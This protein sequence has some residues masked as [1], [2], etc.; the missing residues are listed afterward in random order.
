MGAGKLILRITRLAF[1][2]SSLSICWAATPLFQLLNTYSSG[3]YSPVSLAVADLNGDGKMDV[4]V[5]NLC[6]TYENCPGDGSIGVLLGNGDGTL[7]PPTTYK[8]GGQHTSWVAVGDVNSDGKPDIIT[9]SEWLVYGG[10]GAVGI[11]LGNGDGTFK[12]PVTYLSGGYF[13]E[14]V[15]IADFNHD[16]IP[17]LA[18]ADS[19]SACIDGSC[20]GPGDVSILQGAGDG[21]FQEPKTYPSG[22]YIADSIAAADIN[23][24]GA[25]DLLVGHFG[26]IGVLLGKGDGTFQPARTYSS[27]GDYNSWLAISDVNRDGKL[28]LLVTNARSQGNSA[29]GRVGVLLGNGDGRFQPVTTYRSSGDHASSIAVTNVD[30]D[31]NLDILV[32][33]GHGLNVL[34]GHGDGT[35]VHGAAGPFIA[36]A[37]TVADLDRDG[38]IDVIEA[39]SDQV[40]VL[41]NIIP[42][43]TT[44]SLTSSLNPSIYGQSVTLTAEI[45]FE[46]P[47]TPTGKITF[48]SNGIGIGTAALT[49][50]VATLTK[51]NLPAG[52]LQITAQ[53]TGDINFAR[54]VS[55]PLAQEVQKASTTTTIASSLNPSLQG[56]PVTFVAKVTSVTTRVIGTVT[57]TAGNITL[58]SVA[59]KSGK[60][61]ITTSNLPPGSTEI[62]ATYAGTPN[63]SGS[64]AAVIQVVN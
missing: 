5:A 2:I 31:H 29:A 39:L 22:H 49:N 25:V 13:S 30:R 64:S 4:V 42:F 53:Y 10:T 20:N 7:Q 12:P 63:I 48:R 37:M 51:T 1:L 28:D 17:D 26:E 32:N 23:G 62:T 27:G 11:L 14:S 50:G 19:S 21:T 18:I 16:G 36:Q 55:E 9:S 40:R 58:G 44:T 61:T 15:A 24:D 6:T 47:F 34:W 38:R 3:G 52:S 43:S 54:S 46:G 59:L 57:F 35:F 33:D 41:R 60:A 56:Q 8:S 45:A